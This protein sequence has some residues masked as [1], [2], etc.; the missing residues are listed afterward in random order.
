MLAATVPKRKRAPGAADVAFRHLATICLPTRLGR[1]NHLLLA[2]GGF[3]W[4]CCTK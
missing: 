3:S 4:E 2:C 1:F